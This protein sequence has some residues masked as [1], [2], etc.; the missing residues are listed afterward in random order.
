MQHRNPRV[1]GIGVL[2]AFPDIV[3]TGATTTTAAEQQDCLRCRSVPPADSHLVDGTAACGRHLLAV[4]FQHSGADLLDRGWPLHRTIRAQFRFRKRLVTS[5]RY[6]RNGA[7][8]AF[9]SSSVISA[10]IVFNSAGPA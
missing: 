3:T 6:F 2:G 8:I 4:L 7:D 1:R 10:R 9:N 5:S